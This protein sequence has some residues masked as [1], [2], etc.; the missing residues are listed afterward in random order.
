MHALT[1]TEPGTG[2]TV[3]ELRKLLLHCRWG[4][5]DRFAR[6]GEA[7]QVLTNLPPDAPTNLRLIT[8]GAELVSYDVARICEMTVSL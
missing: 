6:V 7:M 2:L 5:T 8:E 4:A 1:W 3:V